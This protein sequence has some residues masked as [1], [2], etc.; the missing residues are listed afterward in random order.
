[1]RQNLAQRVPSSVTGV[2]VLGVRVSDAAAAAGGGGGGGGIRSAASDP[3][4]LGTVEV[5]RAD[6][7]RRRR[8]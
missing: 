4:A 8:G 6:S 2:A 5:E 3:S 7:K 1:M